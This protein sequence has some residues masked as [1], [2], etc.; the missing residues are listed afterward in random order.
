MI[1]TGRMTDEPPQDL[2]R[3]RIEQGEV[4]LSRAERD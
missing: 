2:A 1:G 4:F 3:M